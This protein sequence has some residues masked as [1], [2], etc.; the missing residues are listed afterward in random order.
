MIGQTVSHYRILEKL[1]EGGMG[2]V[3]KAQDLKLKRTVA[4]KFLP[5]ELT[6]DKSAKTRFIHEAQAASALQHH[7]I[8]TIHEID[9]T[10]DDQLFISM[11]CYQ[12][13]TLKDRIARGPLA[14][15]EALDIAS[16]VAAGLSKAHEAGMV[17]RD[18]KPANIMVTTD[19]VV[20][21]LDFGLAKLAGQTK[22]TKIGTTVGTVSYMSPEQARG[23]EVD[24]RSD[25]FSLGAVFYEM[26]TG[27][28]PFPGDHEAAVLYGIIHG[29]PKPV[30]DFRSDGPAELGPIL[31]KLLSK[32]PSDRYEMLGD[33]LADIRAFK[34]H[35]EALVGTP[36]D[37]RARRRWRN[38]GL[39]MAAAVIIVAAGIILIRSIF[40]THPG[41]IDSIAVLPL[42]NLSKDPG[43]EYF[44]DGMTEALITDLAKIGSIRVTSRTSVMRFKGSQESLP[45]I[46]R[47]LGVH[48]VIEGSVLLVGDRVRISAQLLDA[49]KDRHIWADSYERDVRDVFAVQQEVAR[50]V[51]AAIRVRLTPTETASLRNAAQVDPK[52]HETYLRGRY[53]WNQ[54]TR[55]GLERSVEYLKSAVELDP[56]FA[57]GYAALAEAYIV[58]VTY[59]YGDLRDLYALASHCGEKA[60]EIDGEL[61]PAYA[62][63]AGVKVFSEFDY[64]EAERLYEKAIALD[65]SN[66]TAH[67]CMRSFCRIGAATRRRS[68]S[69]R[70][71]WRSTLCQQLSKGRR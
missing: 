71:P 60:I 23:E 2:V 34:E 61:S 12:G 19:G 10:P 29:E 5:P 54:R 70:R 37:R 55:D 63:L 20:K 21:L 41:K 15:E 9:E 24:A 22:L 44:A 26:L 11:D 51:A 4:L 30:S 3:Y 52:V 31:K 32:V 62:A 57:P 47:A 43:Q 35:K 17:H 13:E 40:T 53:Y 39:A 36:L 69:P 65:P 25:I 56:S 46:A 58:M 8:C 38:L 59:G 33:F 1:G 42:D 48:A 66:S 14:V 6:R 67:Q 27:A 64:P 28:V 16:Q 7:N 18:I 68:A 50:A 49:A 45:E